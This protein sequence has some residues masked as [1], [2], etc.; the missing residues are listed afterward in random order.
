MASSGIKVSEDVLK[1]FDTLKFSSTKGAKKGDEPRKSGILYSVF[2]EDLKVIEVHALRPRSE[3][4]T[5][6]ER[7]DGF[8]DNLVAEFDKKP[9]YVVYDF[10]YETKQGGTNEKLLFVSWY[11]CCI[12]KFSEFHC[13]CRRFLII[14]CLKYMLRLLS[15]VI[16]QTD[17][18]NNIKRTS[19]ELLRCLILLKYRTIYDKTYSPDSKCTRSR[20]KNTLVP[21]GICVDVYIWM[22]IHKVKMYELANSKLSLC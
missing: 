15:S 1:T 16:R 13:H 12:S 17:Y 14:I 5:L 9:V 4:G 10:E 21:I 19:Q 7:F 3:E 22:T 8:L 2:S 18:F 6:K 20:V 11:V